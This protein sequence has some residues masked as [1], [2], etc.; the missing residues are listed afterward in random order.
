[1]ANAN[2]RQLVSGLKSYSQSFSSAKK[3]LL[4]CNRMYSELHSTTIQSKF[5]I[6]SSG[7]GRS[8]NMNNPPLGLLETSHVP[9]YTAFSISIV[10]E[11]SAP[12][13]VLKISLWSKTLENPYHTHSVRLLVI[14]FSLQSALWSSQSTTSSAEYP[15]HS[16][17][18]RLGN[19]SI[20]VSPEAVV[21][22]IHT[23]IIGSFSHSSHS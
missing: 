6:L 8:K 5:D 15:K 18:Q 22:S 19:T 23:G 20:T 11:L 14:S 17:K 7:S 9:V 3:S 10:I 12:K 21:Y 13:V 4:D 16:A 2:C 1:M